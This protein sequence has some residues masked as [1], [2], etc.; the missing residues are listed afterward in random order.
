MVVTS[1]F[2][3]IKKSNIEGGAIK[4]RGAVRLQLGPLL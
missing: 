2:S 1:H 4:Q 3:K